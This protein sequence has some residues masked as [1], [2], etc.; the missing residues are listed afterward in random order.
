MPDNDLQIIS[1]HWSSINI[2]YR[3]FHDV[4]ILL[5]FVQFNN[6]DTLAS[7]YKFSLRVSVYFLENRSREF[8][9]TLQISCP[10]WNNCAMY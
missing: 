8:D 1:P 4:T 5:L 6:T 7:V 2:S 3:D 10:N 9:V